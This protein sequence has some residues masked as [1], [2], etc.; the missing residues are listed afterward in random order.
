MEPIEQL[1]LAALVEVSQ[2]VLGET[3][4]EKLIEKFVR[5]TLEQAGAQRALLIIARSDEYRIEAEGTRNSDAVTVN[6]QQ[7]S[8]TSADLP[9]S[10]FDHVV[11]TKRVLLLQDASNEQPFSTDEYVRRHTTRSI[12]CIPLLRQTRMTGMLYLENI[13]SL[14]PMRTAILALLALEAAFS[15]ES[16]VLYSELR[17]RETKV[18]RV[19]G[20]NIIGICV[21]HFDGRI[22]E[23][24]DAFLDIVGYTRDDLIR[25]HMRWTAMTPPEWSEV[26]TRVI[27]ELRATGTTKPYEKEYFRKNGTRVPVWVGAATFGERQDQG[28]AFVL[29]LTERKRAEEDLRCS[30]RRYHEAELELA[31]ANRVATLGQLT[32][33][34]AHEVNQPIAAVVNHASAALHWLDED[35]PN[36]ERIRSSLTGVVGNGRRAGEV[37]GRIRALLKKVPPQKE[38]MDINEAI[39]EIIALSRG[40]IKKYGISV[41]TFLAEGLSP[42]D[43]DRVQLQQVILNLVVNAVEALSSVHDRPRELTI[44]TVEDQPNGVRVTIRDSG[45]GMSAE[46][47]EQIFDAFYTT[48]SGGLGMGLSISRSIIEAHGGHLWAAANEPHGAS[49]EFALPLHPA[50]VEQ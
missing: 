25:G 30:E 20:S 33:S 44:S 15:I 31:H 43:G 26:H 13:P 1:D 41:Q 3:V 16:S 5:I 50:N 38:S 17:E 36:I 14:V 21:W 37:M 32:A 40:E 39:L 24:N 23:A 48:K 8:V 11:K 49:F 4:L 10:V 7:A 45:P 35:P 34:I 22:I 29:N 9:E 42:V 19:V 27:T 12:L 46:T 6:L 28:F 18:Q 2:A 47:L